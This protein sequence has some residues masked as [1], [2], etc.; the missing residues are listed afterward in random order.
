MATD[1]RVFSYREALQV[2]SAQNVPD[3]LPRTLEILGDELGSAELVRMNGAFSPAVVV[4]GR[5]RILAQVPDHLATETL[6]EV[7]VFS[8]RIPGRG[9]AYL[10][11]LMGP[12]FRTASGA[13]LLMQTFLIYLLQTAG[14]DP[15]APDRGGGIRALLGVTMGA[16]ASSMVDAINVAIVRATDS[17]RAAQAEN[18]FLD[19][20]E[21]LAEARVLG[22]SASRDSST[23]II[24]LEVRSLAG[25]DA[26]AALEV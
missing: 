6:H 7:D 14:S 20:E 2:H 16:D 15:Y 10:D 24:V 25:E 18:P 17:L 1:V 5:S 9:S 19:P 11:F 8:S 21:I 22:S 4:T 26:K 12:G 3:F 13:E 23:V